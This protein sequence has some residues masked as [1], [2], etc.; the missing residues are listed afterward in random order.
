MT[1]KSPF[2]RTSFNVPCVSQLELTCILKGNESLLCLVVKQ[3]YLDTTTP[4][5]APGI[6]YNDQI[7]AYKHKLFEEICVV[8]T[9]AHAV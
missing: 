2:Y 1:W 9:N 6:A 4:T 7:I 5:N 3:R 8:T